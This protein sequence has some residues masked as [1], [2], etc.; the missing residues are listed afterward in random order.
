MKTA[1]CVSF[2]GVLGLLLTGIQLGPASGHVNGDVADCAQM[3][4][5]IAFVVKET[6]YPP[7]QN[8]P[9]VRAASTK[10]LVAIIA[11]DT[12]AQ[13]EDPRA[14]YVAANGE[15]LLSPDVVLATPIGLSYLVH[16]FVHMHQF[17]SGAYAR[18]PCVGWLEGEAYRVQASYLRTHG[19]AKDAFAFEM[20]G[21]LQSACAH[22]YHK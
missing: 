16:E 21:M 3:G 19:L 4:E 6:G 10:A 2:A 5:L 14:A 13:G 1:A 9:R 8:C 12:S 15:I 22:F 11:P 20:L 7:V 17:E 18:A